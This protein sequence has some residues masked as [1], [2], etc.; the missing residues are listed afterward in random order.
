MYSDGN[1]DKLEAFCPNQYSV[2]AFHH[3]QVV[4]CEMTVCVVLCH[5]HRFPIVSG[6]SLGIL[7]FL[8]VCRE[9]V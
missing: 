3:Y 1:D 4:I 8:C 7:C 5:V 2:H 9:G 6:W